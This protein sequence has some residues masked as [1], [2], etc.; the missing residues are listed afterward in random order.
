MDLRL[1]GK[2]ILVTGASRGIGAATARVLSEEG[3]NLVLASRNLEQLESLATEIQREHQHSKGGSGHILVRPL[4]LSDRDSIQAFVQEMPPAL[5]GLVN[6]AGFLEPAPLSATAD[7]TWERTLDINL[8]GPFYLFRELAPR[9]RDDGAIVNISSLAGAAGKDKFPGFGAYTAA[10]MGIVGLGEVMA[11]ELKERRIRV[12]N[13]CPGSVAT[14]MFEIAAPGQKAE[15]TPR[16]VAY[17]VA[18]YLSPLSR[19]FNG[20]TINISWY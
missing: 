8:N 7:I 11:A 14:E 15:M 17:A 2:T 20:Q 13:L 9:L 18:F 19:A 1:E 5:D 3:A 4:D 12:N 6:N 16:E 10:K